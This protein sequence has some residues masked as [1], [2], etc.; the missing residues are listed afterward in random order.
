V[1]GGGA[2]STMGIRNFN[3]RR[4]EDRKRVKIGL[5]QTLIYMHPFPHSYPKFFIYLFSTQYKN[6]S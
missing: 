3:L 5:N 6:Y 1:G 2:K 4:S